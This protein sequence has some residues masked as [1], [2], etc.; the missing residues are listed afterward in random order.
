V[1]DPDA[2][3]VT[4]AGIIM[5]PA[6]FPGRPP[7]E[8]YGRGGFRFGDMS[9]RGSILILPSG[10]HAWKAAATDGAQLTLDDF[11]TV[12]A[13]AGLIDVLLI[14]TG[15]QSA[16]LPKALREGLAT[17]GLR[18]D[19]MSTGAAVRTYNVLVEEDRKVAA[20]LIAV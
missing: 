10:V 3:I 11:A 2:P 13:E 5:K 1:A 16:L 4:P 14:G 12:A 8:A 6:F 15:T 20:A 18:A 17:A 7:I 9:H 19:A